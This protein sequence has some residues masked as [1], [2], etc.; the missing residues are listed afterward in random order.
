MANTKITEH[1][2]KAGSI[3]TGMLHSSFNTDGIT[4]GSSNLFFTNERVDDRVNALL[5]AGTG[6]TLT[7]NDAANTLTVAGAAQ[8][9][10]SDVESYSTDN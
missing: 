10:D 4:E 5:V 7:Y 9:G 3:T 8:Y 2:I 1:V 6:I